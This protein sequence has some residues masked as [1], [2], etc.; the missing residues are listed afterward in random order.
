[1][2]LGCGTAR[3]SWR[4]WPRL[5]SLGHQKPPA[6][7]SRRVHRAACASSSWSATLSKELFVKASE[8]ALSRRHAAHSSVLQGGVFCAVHYS[9]SLCLHAGNLLRRIKQSGEKTPILSLARQ[10]NWWFFKMWRYS[11]FEGND[12]LNLSLRSVKLR[13]RKEALS[14]APRLL[15]FAL[16]DL[17]HGDTCSFTLETQLRRPPVE[18]EHAFWA[19]FAIFRAIP[20]M[21]AHPVIGTHRYNS[22]LKR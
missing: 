1:M 7:F 4:T 15:C 5:T 3:Q 12:S 21:H 20:S 18:A 11:F 14:E 22:F 19:Y 8:H 9:A 16:S 13:N 6:V 17:L 2:R 10:E